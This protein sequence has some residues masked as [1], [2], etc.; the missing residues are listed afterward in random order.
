L[1][2]TKPLVVPETLR[3]LI[4]ILMGRTVYIR[5]ATKSPQQLTIPFRDGNQDHKAKAEEMSR[6]FLK[7]HFHPQ[8]RPLILSNMK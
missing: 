4:Q 8:L 1:V 5:G 6:L 7:G 2:P 3:K